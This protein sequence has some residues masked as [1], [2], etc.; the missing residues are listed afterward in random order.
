MKSAS[1]GGSPCEYNWDFYRFYIDN[2]LQENLS[3]EVA[4]SEVS[5]PVD[6]GLRTFRW[7][8]EKDDASS[9]GKDTV[10]IDDLTIPAVP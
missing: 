8:Y 3:G 9:E 4:W 6:A 1:G 7:E 5:F 2:R 10:Y